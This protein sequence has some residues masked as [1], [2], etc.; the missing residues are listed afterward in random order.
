[1]RLLVV[2]KVSGGGNL[3]EHSR[4]L[5]ASGEAGVEDTDVCGQQWI[6]FSVGAWSYIRIVHMHF[7]GKPRFQNGEW[8][9]PRMRTNTMHE[10]KPAG[11]PVRLFIIKD[12][13][14]VS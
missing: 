7:L 13:F 1:M 4:S 11:L 9:N 5:P 2:K 12:R 10:L 3:D 6:E 14:Q 8:N